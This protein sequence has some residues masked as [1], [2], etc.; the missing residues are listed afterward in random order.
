M[1][2]KNNSSATDTSPVSESK[3]MREITEILTVLLKEKETR[4]KGEKVKRILWIVILVMFVYNTFIFFSMYRYLSSPEFLDGVKY[5]AIEAMPRISEEL[6]K[7]AEKSGPILFEQLRGQFEAYLPI[8]KDKILEQYTELSNQAVEV[9]KQQF[10]SMV[11]TQ[12]EGV[13]GKMSFS[14]GVNVSPEQMTELKG[15]M[16][17]TFN[18]SMNDII[19]KNVENQLNKCIAGAEVLEKFGETIDK[20]SK[21]LSDTFSTKS[22][23]ERRKIGFDIV[24]S[25]L[26]AIDSKATGRMPADLTGSA[27]PEILLPTPTK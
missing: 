11:D 21:D 26:D 5:R 6:G 13:L 22:E 27:I 20:T 18:A 15:F 16:T 1:G 25:F 4:E 17:E 24:R 10:S 8:M 23:T 14:G 19:S 2:I 7:T 12:I 3:K 9:S